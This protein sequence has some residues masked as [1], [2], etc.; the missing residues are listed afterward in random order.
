MNDVPSNVE[1]AE[2]FNLLPCPIQES[3]GNDRHPD[4]MECCQLLTQIIILLCSCQL[5][6]QNN[7]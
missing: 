6:V 7:I 4:E 2:T 5:N 1:K 3:G